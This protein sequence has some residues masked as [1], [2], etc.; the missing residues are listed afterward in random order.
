MIIKI[1]DEYLE[2]DGDVEMERQVMNIDNFDNV[3]DFS[4]SF[5]VH[6]T[7]HNKKLLGVTAIDQ[8]NKTLFTQTDNAELQTDGGI[9]IHLGSIIVTNTFGIECSF[10]SGN[11]NFF[12]YITGNIKDINLKELDVIMSE[13][14]IVASWSN[15]SGIV[16]PIVDR[17]NLYLRKDTFL[18]F[19]KITGFIQENDF[20]P[21][22]YIKDVIKKALT[23]HGLKI[24][25]DLIE[26]K[27]YQDLITTNNDSDFYKK[28]YKE[29]SVSIGKTSSQTL[30]TTF[31]QITFQDETSVQYYN[32][33]ESPYDLST[34]RWEVNFNNNAIPKIF[35]NT[36]DP[37][38][39][40]E[41]ELR[42]NGASVRDWFVKGLSIELT[43]EVFLPYYVPGD[44]VELWGRVFTSGTVDIIGGA[45]TIE[46]V[47]T[48]F[49]LASA[50]VPDQETKEFIKDIF[51]M[52]NV[53]CTF[54][55]FT[56]TIHTR[57]FKNIKY[58]DEQDLSEYVHIL[59]AENG[60][61]LVSDYSKENIIGYQQ[62]DI[63]EIEKYNAEHDID[64]GNG[65]IDV[66]NEM[67]DNV[68]SLYDV[69]YT[70][71][72]SSY[73]P[74]FG[75]QLIRLDYS[76][77]NDALGIDP[78]IVNT[79]NDNAGLAEVVLPGG[80]P[81]SITLSNGGFVGDAD[82]V[83]IPTQFEEIDSDAQIIAL[84]V[85]NVS[86]PVDIKFTE[87]TTSIG[88]QYQRVWHLYDFTID[89]YNGY[90][91]DTAFV[92]APRSN[93]SV[94]VFA[95]YLDGTPLDTLKQ[96]LSFGEI[97]GKDTLTLIE[98]YYRDFES[99]LNDP[100]KPMI[101]MLIPEHV[102]FNLDFLKP[103][104]IKTDRFNS[105]FFLQKISGYKNSYTPCV[106]ELIKL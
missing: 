74:Y 52:F 82:G 11:T 68:S 35:L 97:D 17:G 23:T 102:Y 25:G 31:S 87:W 51:K 57:L 2:F 86:L 100:I 4:Y 96:G 69:N 29:N 106:F 20:Q 37:N 45:F 67:I 16:F 78:F 38:I 21:F 50:L 59:E 58:Q 5:T 65:S 73:Y 24:D 60:F 61:D 19:T 30:T 53:V 49:A 85:P 9:T 75:L 36:S 99:V 77:Y 88:I 12:K 10:V 95:K 28:R 84:N 70:A 104:R 105:L 81:S 79:V 22:I 101:S 18:S 39:E 43:E 92:R 34:N 33:L 41:F 103:V 8:K 47:R 3:G 44:Y 32:S 83:A 56:K 91:A 66:N 90:W 46:V 89:Q 98:T 63:P 62:L 54:D 76:I 13:S 6:P 7:A 26:D 48:D 80:S 42:R 64:Y 14:N 72:Y 94:A 93:A 1:G 27:T 71:P 55:V 40:L 15:T